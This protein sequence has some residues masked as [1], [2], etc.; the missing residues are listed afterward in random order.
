MI[1]NDVEHILMQR[2]PSRYRS[3]PLENSVLSVIPRDI[4]SRCFREIW[5]GPPGASTSEAPAPFPEEL[6]DRLVRMFSFVGDTVADP[7]A[8]TGTTLVSAAKG[9]QRHRL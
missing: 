8:G 5:D 1:K 4:H 2:K 7:F 3:V 6:S 9:T